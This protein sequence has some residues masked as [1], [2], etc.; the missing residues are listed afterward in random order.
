MDHAGQDATSVYVPIH[1]SDTLDKNLPPEKHLGV[2]DE[3]SIQKLG[4][5][6]NEKPKTRDELRVEE[7]IKN[8]PPLSR[9]VNVQDIEVSGLNC[10]RKNLLS[11]TPG[12]S[13]TTPSVQSYGVLRISCRRLR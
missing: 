7:A 10:T 2:L 13:K 4:A 9:M 12:N 11:W 5:L 1:P 8:K 3:A 6:V